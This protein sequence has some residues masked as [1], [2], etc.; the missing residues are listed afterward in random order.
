[1]FTIKFLFVLAVLAA[2][3]LGG[4][5]PLWRRS[6]LGQGRVLGW[7]NAFTAGIFLG[8][9]WIHMLPDAAA[10]WRDLGWDYPMA[11]ALAAFGFVVMLLVEVEVL[12]QLVEMPLEQLL[13]VVV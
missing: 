2:G 5:L 3:A 9:G 12:A 13:V 11:F 10:G 6:A 1:M 8:A 7:G 4:A